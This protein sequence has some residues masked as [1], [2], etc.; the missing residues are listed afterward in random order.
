MDEA[1]LN[2]Q[3]LPD[4]GIQEDAFIAYPD[5]TEI[6]QEQQIKKNEHIIILMEKGLLTP[7]EAQEKI[8]Y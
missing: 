8:Q 5:I 3:Y 1:V 4:W 7:K 6:D 2:S